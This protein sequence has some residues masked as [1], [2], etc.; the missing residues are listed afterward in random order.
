M[1]VKEPQLLIA[2][3]SF[4]PLALL[5]GVFGLTS[6]AYEVL[7]VRM[8]SLQFGVSIFAVVLTVAAFMGGLGA[9]S[10]FAVRRASRIKSPLSFIAALEGW[11][12]VYDLCVL[13]FFFFFVLFVFFFC[14]FFND[15]ATTEIYTRS[16]VG[17][18]RCV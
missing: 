1:L 3:R 17:S 12:A 8:L 5:Y 4:W 2:K 11:I 13:R 15:T 16:L 7:W 14:C 18:V 6:V 9:G 10:L